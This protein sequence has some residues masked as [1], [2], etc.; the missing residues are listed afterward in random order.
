[1]L[2]RAAGWDE[3]R[4]AINFF[5]S[6]N[7][8]FVYADVEGNIG[9][10]T[11][12]GIPVRKGDGTIIRNGETDEFDWKGYVPFEQLPFSYNPANGYVSSANN[13]T[14]IEGYPYY[15][16]SDFALPYRINRIRQML[17]EKETFNIED[18]KRMILDQYSD[19]A[20]L[21]TPFILKLNSKKQELTPLEVKALET[22]E[23]WDYDMNASL[24]APSVFEF[25]RI[26]FI[27]NLLADELG[28]LYPQLFKTTRDYYIY[29][30]IKNGP[31]VWVDNINTPQIETL[32]DI[33]LKSFRDCISSLSL[34][35]G[36][37][38]SKWEWGSIHKITIEHPLGSVKI[39][40]RIFGL[41]SATYGIGGSDHTVSVYSYGEGFKVNHGASERHIFNTADWD[42]SF[43][44]TPT[45]ASGVPASEFYLSQ[46]KAYLEGKFYKDA[47]SE[48]AVKASAKYTLVLKPGK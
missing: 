15:I 32:D 43:T 36:E 17:D 44:I 22:L 12:A 16:S 35:Y 5:K 34:Q 27:Y 2:N 4:S 20:A 9:L 8:N 10:N 33:I 38:Q 40:D 30:I 41:N 18:F 26:S 45:G 25:F 14:V 11:G 24:V 23:G 47:F 6:A 42:E 28:D 7:Q 21:L 19:Y 39:L 31:D 48:K 37:D 46:T 29:R 1:L 3:F 13:K